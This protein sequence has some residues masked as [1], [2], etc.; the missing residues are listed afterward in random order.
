MTLLNYIDKYGDKSFDEERFNEVDN[1]ILASISYLDLNGIVSTGFTNKITIK[2]ASEKY[3]SIDNPSKDKMTAYKSSKTILKK[4]YNKK[5]YKDLLLYNYCYIGTVDQQFSAVTIEINPKLIYISYEGTDNLVSGWE[6]DFKIA[7]MFPVKAQRNAINYIN[8]FIFTRKNIIIGGHS[9]GGNLAL[10]AGMY[11]NR[12][13]KKRIINIYCNDGPGL[14]KREFMSHEY[15][16]AA[17]KLISIIPNQSIVGLLL[18]HSNKYIVI[19]S[20][21]RGPLSHDLLSWQVDGTKLKRSELSKFSQ[22][23][24]KSMHD[25]LKKYD[26]ETRKIFVDSLFDIFR[27]AG[28]NDLEEVLRKKTLIFK[29]IVEAGGLSKTTKSM[30]REFITVLYD[31]SKE[32]R[33][34]NN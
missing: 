1:V 30:M 29:L 31:Y 2:E 17:L 32:T 26:D 14:R 33:K 24:D 10:V 20:N 15:R 8:K 27:R 16:E 3:F 19:E 34:Q 11:A 23:F 18:R 4:I 22:I 5:R 28:I 7:Y 9:K 13:T 12:F 25:W 6:E 21:K